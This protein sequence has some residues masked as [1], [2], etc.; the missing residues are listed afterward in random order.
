MSEKL[1]EEL[2]SFGELWDG[3][4]HTGDPLNPMSQADF[5]RLNYISVLHAT[6]L[7]CIKPYVN[8]RT[9]ALEIGP[10][11]GC[12]TKTLLPA[13]DVWALDA[14]SAE[15]NRFFEYLGHPKN[16]QYFQVSDFSC[17][18]LPGDYF[19]YMFSFNC[20]CHVSF[21]GIRAYA[22]NLYPKLKAG[23][24]C[25]WMIADYN[26]YNSAVSNTELDLWKTLMPNGR[27]Y[28]PL[29]F[30]FTKML[31]RKNPVPIILKTD[32]HDD[33]VPGRWYDAGIERTCNMLQEIGYEIAD[34][35][36]GTNLRDPIIHFVKA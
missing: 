18:M 12:W 16:V 24:N 11:R 26:K 17:G 33:P 27:R 34:P 4:Y 28:R 36:V 31:E 22:T 7:R 20:L 29:T 2:K 15:H 35:D 3:G 30:L 1:S 21:D 5:G 14:L 32:G 13:K 9:T 10:G 23:S 19:T 6:Y 25:F 8:S